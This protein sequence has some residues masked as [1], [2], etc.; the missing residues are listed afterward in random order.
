MMDTDCDAFVVSFPGEM[1]ECFSQDDADALASARDVLTDLM[2]TEPSL[3]DCDR[4]FGM[5]LPYRRISAGE[6][7]GY[8]TPT[9]L[10]DPTPV[11]VGV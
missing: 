2:G 1:V 4:L 3:D 7:L 10:S 5:E 8:P 11:P 9:F 6:G